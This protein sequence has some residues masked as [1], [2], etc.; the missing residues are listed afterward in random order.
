MKEDVERIGSD[1]NSDKYFYVC[2]P[3]SF[4]VFFFPFFWRELGGVKTDNQVHL[5]VTYPGFLSVLE[6]SSFLLL[7]DG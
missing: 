1:I 3:G 7:L 2:L 4:G 5:I 6:L